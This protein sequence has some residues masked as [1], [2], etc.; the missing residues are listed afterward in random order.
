VKKLT[1][2]EYIKL[3]E[4]MVALQKKIPK[5]AKWVVPVH[6]GWVRYWN[7]V[8]KDMEKFEKKYAKDSDTTVEQLHKL[9]RY[10]TPCD[11]GEDGCKGWQMG[12]FEEMTHAE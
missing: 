7:K 1:K 12:H 10:A 9:G 6:P 8:L 2:E 5:N 4:E 3:C 11:C